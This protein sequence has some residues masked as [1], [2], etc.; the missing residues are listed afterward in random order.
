MNPLFALAGVL[1]LYMLLGYVYALYLKDNSVADILYG[2]AVLLLALVSYFVWGSFGPGCV[3]TI[4]SIVWA[5]RLSMRIYLKHRG[6]P[7]DARY[8]QWRTAWMQRSHGYF[9]VRTLLQVF[10]LQGIVIFIVALPVVL[11]NIYGVSGYEW[12]MALGVCMWIV[13]FLFEAI[14][15]YQLDR[16]VSQPENKGTICTVGLWKYSRHPNYFGEA[17]MWW[18]MAV[19]A[20][21]VLPSG[22]LVALSF[23]SPLLI[24]YLLLKVSGVPMLEALMKDKPGWNEYAARTNAFIP[25]FPKK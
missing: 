19:A 18:G 10:A 20:T 24:T 9:L 25:W 22:I 13:G 8:A 7:E 6:R 14:G 11:V 1:G 15:D 17:L 4:L 12:L 3:L 2:K 21:P 5:V 23:C 16:Y